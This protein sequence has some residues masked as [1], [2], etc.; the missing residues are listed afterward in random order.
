MVRPHRVGASII[1]ACSGS[2]ACLWR[3]TLLTRTDWDILTFWVTFFINTFQSTYLTTGIGT[4][5]GTVLRYDE[6]ILPCF[7]RTEAVHC[8]LNSTIDEWIQCDVT[9]WIIYVIE[10]IAKPII[11]D[12]SLTIVSNMSQW[13]LVQ[14]VKV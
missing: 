3:T 8:I 1:T 10:G 6:S 2:P 4:G 5:T 7:T 14:A 13:R 11:V 9:G 12:I